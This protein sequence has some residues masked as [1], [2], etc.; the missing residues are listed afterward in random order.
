L[1]GE[2]LPSWRVISVTT[3]RCARCRRTPTQI[4]AG[5]SA[6]EYE[7][8]LRDVI[9]AFKYEGR[10]TLAHPLGER[11][12]A[13]ARDLLGNA[14]CVVP[15]P[16]HPWRRLMRGFNQAADLAER[17]GPPVVHA[18]WRARATVPQ[19]GLRAAARRRN[20]RHAIS[21]SPIMRPPA[22]ERHVRGR[23][24]LVVDD[25]RTTGATL[26]ACARALKAAGAKE[27]R[28]ATVAIAR[29]VR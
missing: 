14:D 17:L 20:L 9:H 8:A 6:G 21:L 3:A 28:T 26:D 29:A 19:T 10:R 15:V 1:C 12:R 4:D 25:V 18:L 13:A 11:L 23:I 2:P 5:V 7:G 27:V 24:V 16:L 22:L